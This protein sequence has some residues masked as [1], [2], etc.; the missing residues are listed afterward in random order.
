MPRVHVSRP[1]LPRER[2]LKVNAMAFVDF[3]FPQVLHDLGLTY[4]EGDFFSQAASLEP[5]SEIVAT[6]NEGAKLALAI[7]TEKAKSDF[8]IAPILLELWRM[9][10]GTFG[11]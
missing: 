3:T 11:L 10:G 4:R 7:G 5:G 9:L 1:L 2:H 8:I 6:L